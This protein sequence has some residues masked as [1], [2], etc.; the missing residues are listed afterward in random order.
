VGIGNLPIQV[1]ELVTDKVQATEGD[2]ST[3]VK[4]LAIVEVEDDFNL[5]HMKSVRKRT[6][7]SALTA[8]G[9]GSGNTD[10]HIMHREYEGSIQD[11]IY[12]GSGT[13]ITY[14]QLRTNLSISYAR[15]LEKR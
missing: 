8:I 2:F 15:L 13:G 11:T 3:R 7:P 6:L 10:Q 4:L 9:I 12:T 14:I 1:F 5:K